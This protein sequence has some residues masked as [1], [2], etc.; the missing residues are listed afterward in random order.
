[1]PDRLEFVIGGQRQVALAATPA[2]TSKGSPWGGF[3]VEH[4]QSVPLEMPDHWIPHYLVNLQLVP[5]P[6]KRFFFESGREHE[7]IVRY[8][9]CVVVAPHEVRRFRFSGSGRGEMVCVS[10]E[11]EILIN[12]IAGRSASNPFELLR[13]CNGDDPKLR[14][15]ISGLRADLAAGCPTGPLLGESLCTNLAEELI[16][17]YSIGRARLDERKGGLSGL[18]LRRSMEYIEAHL[19][20][21]LTGDGI[22]RISGLSKYHFGKSF[23]QSTGVTLHSYVLARR[24][25]RSQ[26]LLARSGLPLAAIADLAGFSNQSHFTTVFSTR[27]GISPSSYR[28]SQKPVSVSMH[29][30]TT[31]L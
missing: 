9:D 11:P 25:R 19:N 28:E 31:F 23:K 13:R 29:T 5:G 24:M 15:L 30:A 2:L 3:F 16:R 14:N 20:A 21:N 10:I 22:A 7:S 12:M 1:M 26:E 4:H 17:R 8:G 27:T 6:A 18:Q